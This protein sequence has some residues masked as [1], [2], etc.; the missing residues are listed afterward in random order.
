MPGARRRRSSRRGFVEKTLN[1]ITEFMQNEVFSEH[2]AG[3]PGLLQGI[4]PRAKLV[5]VLFLIF[6]AGMFRHVFPLV[7]Y[8]LWLFWLARSSLVPFRTFV[9]R[10]WGMVA[11]FTGIVAFPALFNVVRPGT[12]LLTLFH[13]NHPVTLGYLTIPAVVT[14]TR[15]GVAAAALL[16]LRTGASVSL[17]VLLTLTTRWNALLKAIHVLRIPVVFIAV[18]DMSY[19]YIFLLLQTSADMFMARRSRLVG[20]AQ[21][22]EERRFVASA[23][24][25]LWG[26]TTALSE[27]VHGAMLARGYAGA[28]KSLSLFR[29]KRSDWLWIALVLVVAVLFMGSERVFA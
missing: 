20:R 29:M 5:T 9:T 1:A 22:S 7:L 19:R 27:E 8:N 12:P 23:M 15:E 13:L 25:A 10:V 3:E 4:D 21:S 17:A 6:M 24:G 11:L 14:I 18:L 26:K 16:M 2:L 28:P